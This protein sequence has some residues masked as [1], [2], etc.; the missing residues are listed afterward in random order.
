MGDLAFELRWGTAYGPAGRSVAADI[1]TST[2]I[3]STDMASDGGW[4][5]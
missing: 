5:R 2:L 1:S 4:R 3:T